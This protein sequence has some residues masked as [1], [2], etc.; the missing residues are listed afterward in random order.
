MMVEG[1]EYGEEYGM[2]V[3]EVELHMMHLWY[4]DELT[5]PF[6]LVIDGWI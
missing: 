5:G 4:E 6:Y 2:L 1:E 3:A